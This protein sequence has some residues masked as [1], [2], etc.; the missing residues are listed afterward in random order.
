MESHAQKTYCVTTIIYCVHYHYIH[1]WA[2]GSRRLQLPLLIKILPPKSLA[3][4][5]AQSR[6]ELRTTHGKGP[7]VLLFS[8]SL[9]I[10]LPLHCVMVWSVHGTII[11]QWKQTSMLIIFDKST[12]GYSM[13]TYCSHKCE[14]CLSLLHIYTDFAKSVAAWWITIRY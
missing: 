2:P 9:Q 14:G 11:W 6:E 12:D 5:S 10:G 8:C 13:N 1:L 4:D 3:S 7:F